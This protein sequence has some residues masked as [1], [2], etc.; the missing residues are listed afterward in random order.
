MSKLNINYS[1]SAEHALDKNFYPVIKKMQRAGVSDIWLWGMFSGRHNSGIENIVKAKKR[2]E[3]E[4]YS[5]GT[6]FVPVGHP[7][8][9]LNPDDETIDLMI[10]KNWAYRADRN[11]NNVYF[12]GCVDDELINDNVSG[13]LL[14]KET[15]ITRLF[16]DDDARIGNWGYYVQGCF[17]DKCIDKFNN[18]RGCNYSRSEIASL[19]DKDKAFAE[20]WMD[21][22]CGKLTRFVKKTADTGIHTGIM[23]MHDGD[24]RHGI[25]I[26]MLMEAVPNLMVRVGELHFDNNS[27]DQ[28]SGK[29]SLLRSA[30]TH[31]DLVRSAAGNQLYEDIYS[32]TTVFP[33]RA[34]SP[35]NMVKKAKLELMAG[36]PKLFL[37]GGTAIF[38]MEY[39][40][41]FI[42][43]REELQFLHE[44]AEA[45]G[46]YTSRDIKEPELWAEA[47][48]KKANI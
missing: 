21:Y 24:R 41:A 43:A 3:E 11:G 38:D 1:I 40:D 26:K 25:D 44:E 18:L 15:G 16:L 31:A 4:G 36:I 34:L 23:I 28:P 14:Y 19:I 42:E 5:V 33:S 32:E 27:F 2:L 48:L 45:Y 29:I 20:S 9:S 13:A 7:G 30:V 39:W 17:C 37:M 10:P 46:Y 12:C 22:N 6:V 35:Q 8:N 47:V